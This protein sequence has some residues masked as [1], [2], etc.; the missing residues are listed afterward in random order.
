VSSRTARAIEKPCLE[1]TKTKTKKK[2]ER[3]KKEI[4]SE[5]IIPSDLKT[6]SH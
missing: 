1:K 4:T 2:K 5:S 6:S 3:K